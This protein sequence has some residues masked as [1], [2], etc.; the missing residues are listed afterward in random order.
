M[1]FRLLLSTL[2]LIGVGS[3]SPNRATLALLTTS[4]SSTGNVF[5]AGTVHISDSLEAGT[6]L[7]MENL[8]AGDTFDAELRIANAGSLGLNYALTTSTSGNGTLASE[9]LVKIRPRTSNPCTSHDGLPVLYS[10]ALASAVVGNP[11]HGADL[12]DRSLGAG[13]TEVLCFTIEL[14]TSVT[15]QDALVTASFLF[16]AEQS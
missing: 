13:A 4:A 3:S 8:I 2:F 7:S 12:N 14:P 15:T 9:I 10:G 16:D 1:I 11:A 5:S 6:T